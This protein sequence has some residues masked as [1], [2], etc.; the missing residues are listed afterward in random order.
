MHTLLY[1]CSYGAITELGV[2]HT[3]VSFNTTEEVFET[4]D[5]FFIQDKRIYLDFVNIY[6]LIVGLNESPPT[7]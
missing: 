4:L 6:G 2:P 1:S 5:N 7:V 3:Y